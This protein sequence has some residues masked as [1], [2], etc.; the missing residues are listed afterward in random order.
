MKVITNNN[1][2]NNNNQKR[3]TVQDS[4]TDEKEISF[5]SNKQR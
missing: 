1:N 3:K 4:Q 2:N 5:G